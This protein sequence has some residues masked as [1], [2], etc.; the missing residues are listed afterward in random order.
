MKTARTVTFVE[1]RD[2]RHRRLVDAARILPVVA[3]LLIV[4]PLLWSPEAGGGRN[5]ARDTVYI[6]GL[7]V[8][9]IVLARLLALRLD[10]GDDEDSESSADTGAAED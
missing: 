3:F 1:C 2:Y 7:W 8:G 4:L 5:L 10:P 9:M 6:F